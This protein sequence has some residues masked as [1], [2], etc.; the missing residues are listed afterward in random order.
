MNKAIAIKTNMFNLLKITNPLVHSGGIYRE[1]VLVGKSA[2][3][4]FAPDKHR[5]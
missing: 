2:S 1:A 5:Q 3:V 4:D